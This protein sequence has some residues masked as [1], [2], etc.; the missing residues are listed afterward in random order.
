MTHVARSRHLQR[1]QHPP[2]TQTIR[3]QLLQPVTLTLRRHL[4][5]PV[6]LNIQGHHLQ[7]VTLQAGTLSSQIL[8]VSPP[9]RSSAGN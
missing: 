1:K 6:T 4:L 8:V 2:V 5:Q 3:R 7:P 9:S